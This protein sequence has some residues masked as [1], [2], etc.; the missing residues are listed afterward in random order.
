MPAA[1]AVTP[2][3]LILLLREKEVNRPAAAYVRPWAAEV[4]ED[5]LLGA[6]GLLECVGKYGEPSGV[7]MAGRQFPLR[8]GRLGQRVDRGGQPDG[9]DG[10]G[11][12]GVAEH[13]PQQPSL[14]YF[15]SLE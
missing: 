13:I 11:A 2:C 10:D 5:G 9:V 8:V 14:S 3:S 7:E 1:S 15:L 4:I 6:P 12:E